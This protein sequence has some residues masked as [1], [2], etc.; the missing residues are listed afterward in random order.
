MDDYV[1]KPVDKQTLFQLLK[2]YNLSVGK[3]D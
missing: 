2:K 1:P 3:A